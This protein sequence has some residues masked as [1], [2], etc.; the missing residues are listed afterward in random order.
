M[1]LAHDC[2]KESLVFK[3][4]LHPL[5][6]NVL[7]ISVLVAVNDSTFHASLF[8]APPPLSGGIT[9]GCLPAVPLILGDSIG[10][11]EDCP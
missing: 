2:F 8:L 10:Q 1:L 5:E 3:D 7:T 11:D 4:L 6:N 9:G